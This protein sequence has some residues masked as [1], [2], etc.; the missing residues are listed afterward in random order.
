MPKSYYIQG[1]KPRKAGLVAIVDRDPLT[2]AWCLKA[3][4][5]SKANDSILIIDEMDKLQN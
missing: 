5:L 1:M 4:A 2:Q 3:G